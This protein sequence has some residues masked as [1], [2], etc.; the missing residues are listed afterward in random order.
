VTP[1]TLLLLAAVACSERQFKDFNVPRS[2]EDVRGRLLPLVEGHPVAEA[3]AY[4]AQRGVPC[5]PP[6]PSA[7][8]ARVHICH[9]AGR[10][11]TID[12]Y[13]RNSRIADVQA[14]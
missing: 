13:E 4:L 2:A 9:P 1:R 11:W 12:L 14:R 8:D 5:D 7:T 3:L 6:L 10:P